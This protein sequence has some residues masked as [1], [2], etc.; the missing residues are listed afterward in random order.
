MA[1]GKSSKLSA[2][3]D[4][5]GVAGKT[6]TVQEKQEEKVEK[7]A[8][9]TEKPINS[10]KK[11]K[12]ESTGENDIQLENVTKEKEQKTQTEQ[13]EIA[14][15]MKIVKQ[16]KNL[17]NIRISA[18]LS[19]KAATNLDKLMEKT[20]CNRNEVLNQLLENIFGD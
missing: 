1:Q 7:E 4:N 3:F 10:P 5:F 8:I 17:R 19:A 15:G 13:V 2:S 6:T 14:S 11:S 12:E 18:L 16:T 9:D 20:G